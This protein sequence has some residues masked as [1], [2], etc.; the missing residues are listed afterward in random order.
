MTDEF[1]QPK[2]FSRDKL[3]VLL[4]LDLSKM[5]PNP[6]MRRADG[7]FPARMGEAVRTRAASSTRRSATLRTRGT[8]ETLR[9][10]Y[11]EAI[12]WALRLTEGDATP[13]PQPK[14]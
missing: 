9:Q 1:Y 5:P 11:F 8:T 4:R 10:M 3:R 12:K 14:D 2:E 13:R 6:N 7:D